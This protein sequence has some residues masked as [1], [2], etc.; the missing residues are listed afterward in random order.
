MALDI[1]GYPSSWKYPFVAAEIRFNQGVSSAPA[2]ART[3]LVVGPKTPAGTWLDN[4]VYENATDEASVRLGAGAGSPLHRAARMIWQIDK[5]AKVSFLVTETDGYGTAADSTFEIEFDT[6]TNPTAT[7]KFTLNL[8]GQIVEVGFKPSDTLT[9]ISAQIVASINQKT[10][11]PYIA[12]STTP[13]FIDVTA[14][15]PGSNG[16]DGTTGNF[17]ATITVEPGK[18]ITVSQTG[19]YL[20]LGAGT[21]GVDGTLTEEDALE[22]ALDTITQRSEYYILSNVWKPTSLMLLK[23]Y[24]S[25]RNEPNPG[26]YGCVVV[27]NTMS[28]AAAQSVATSINNHLVSICHQAGSSHDSMELA[29]ALGATLRKREELDPT[30][31]L[32]GYAGADWPILPPSDSSLWPNADDLNDAV[33]DGLSPVE[34]INSIST[35]LGMNITTQSKSIDGSL[36]DWR[37]AERHRVS[38]MHQLMTLLKNQWALTFAMKKLAPDILDS[39]GQV[40]PGAGLRTNVITPSIAKPFVSNVITKFFED[41]HLSELAPVLESLIM[42]VDPANKSRLQCGFSAEVVNHLNQTSFLAA[43]VNAG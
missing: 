13:G 39:S 41:G 43:E 23:A 10:E 18:N 36:N 14:K 40:V 24:I 3:M 1:L 8:C 38:G 33:L 30:V 19:E 17:K 26:I 28:L 12:S 9:T 4:V 27:G 21:A 37:S 35:R 31:N 34:A 32:N 11:L 20:G 7:G 6:G 29:A 22:A 16:G 25:A 2:G 15:I 42:Q 5:N